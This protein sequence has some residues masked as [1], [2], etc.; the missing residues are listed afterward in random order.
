M[1]IV[2][3]DGTRVGDIKTALGHAMDLSPF[4]CEVRIKSEKIVTLHNIRLKHKKRYCGSH[5]NFCEVEGGRMGTWLEGADWV[6]F[7]D[8]L[9]DVLDI[10]DVKANVSSTICI[11]RKGKLR[12]IHYGSHETGL[13]NQPYE[14][15]R[16]EDDSNY[17]YHC[18]GG[19]PDS[20]FPD[21]TPGMYIRVR[22]IYV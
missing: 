4:T 21:G 20:T 8:L 2:V 17:E 5:P 13:V 11:L 3:Q 15:N 7:N 22:N 1:K 14:W 18:L 6:A 12:R 16:D 19:A 10:L 9:N